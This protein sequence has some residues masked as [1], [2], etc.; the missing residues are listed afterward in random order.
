M[1]ET[2][3]R[4]FWLHKINEAWEKTS[5]IWLYGVRRIG[6]TFLCRSIGDTEYFDCELPRTRRL[7]DDSEEFYKSL[8]AK[9]IIIDEIHRLNNPSE[10]LKIG[11]DYYPQIK[12]IA[13]GSSTLGSSKKFK[14]TL[15]GRKKDLWLLP[16]TLSDLADFGVIDIKHRLYRGGLPPFFLAKNYPQ[17]EFQDWMDDFWA[18]DIVELFR[19]ERR[20]S[21]QKCIELIFMQSGGIFEANAFSGSC[22]VSRTTIANYLKVLE[23]TS[24][25]FIIRPY[26]HQKSGEIVSAP[27][28]YGFDTGFVA[29]FK[30]WERLRTDDMGLLWEHFVLNELYANLQ[31]KKINYWRDKRGHEIDFVIIHREHE[32]TAIEAKWK[33]GDFD[34]KNLYAFRRRYPQ[35]TNYVVSSDV[36]RI[37][38]RKYNGIK[39][40]FTGLKRL[41]EAEISRRTRL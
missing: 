32:P 17:Y 22:E 7:F 21:F 10:L 6:K 37:F 31:T 4:T 5:L 20:Y 3:K 14:D 35:G 15:T 41:V 30:G 40:I 36:E 39:V 23:A 19:L 2:V 33:A 18:K 12:I 34:P 9:K 26:A 1:V 28:V 16:M 8:T 29:Y 38:S 13:T 24:V 27:K 11:A 25:V